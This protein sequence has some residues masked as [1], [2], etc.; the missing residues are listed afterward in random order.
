MPGRDGSP[1]RFLRDLPAEGLQRLDRVTFPSS[2]HAARLALIAGCNVD[3]VFQL[4][5]LNPIYQ[6][7]L[8]HRPTNW[9]LFLK[10]TG[11]TLF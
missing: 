11:G 3:P 10:I 1:A 7:A 9:L 5:L 2:E 6:P 4:S 8:T